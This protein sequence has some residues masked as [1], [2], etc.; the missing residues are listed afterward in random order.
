MDRRLTDKEKKKL[1]ESRRQ[2]K[3]FGA[4]AFNVMR[5]GILRRK[6]REAK[7]KQAGL[8]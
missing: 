7:T 1:I 2:A 5:R 6:V 4:V 3:A 8:G